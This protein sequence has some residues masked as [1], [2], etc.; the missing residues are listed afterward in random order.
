MG[1]G[2]EMLRRAEDWESAVDALLHRMG[3][4]A[5]RLLSPPWRLVAVTGDG[6][7]YFDGSWGPETDG[8]VATATKRVKVADFLPLRVTVNGSGRGTV[9]GV[10]NNDG[11]GRLSCA[12]RSRATVRK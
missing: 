8:T 10:I 6:K 12:I 2:L 9:V 5:A 1:E 7:V 11:A 4:E 3:D